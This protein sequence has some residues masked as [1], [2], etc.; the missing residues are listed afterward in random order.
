MGIREYF[1]GIG[2][3]IFKPF[4]RSSHRLSD[5]NSTYKKL[6][7]VPSECHCTQL[8]LEGRIP[9]KPPVPSDV[10]ELKQFFAAKRL[11]PVYQNTKDEPTSFGPS[12]YHYNGC[13]IVV[14]GPHTSSFIYGSAENVETVFGELVA[15]GVNV[16]APY[17]F[18][19]ST[20][21][22]NESR[23]LIPLEQRVE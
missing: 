18:T 15:S 1:I 16:R 2:Y 5:E 6:L 20:S 22:I 11:D 8:R 3:A 17:F 12:V 23:Q 9:G 14:K 19:Q 10:Y 7:V 4:G 21:Q 13:S